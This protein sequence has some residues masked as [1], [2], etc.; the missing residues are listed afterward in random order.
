MVG[1]KCGEPGERGHLDIAAP[2]T[3]VEVAEGTSI[4]GVR[5]P[6]PTGN[7]GIQGRNPTTATLLRDTL[8]PTLNTQQNGDLQQ[9]GSGT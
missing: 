7:R 6:G 9:G 1:V 8:T 4:A 3:V 5:K 2:R